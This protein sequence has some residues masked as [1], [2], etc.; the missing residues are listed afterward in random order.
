VTDKLILPPPMPEAL[1]EARLDR[2]AWDR[3][4]P[5]VAGGLDD[6]PAGR[7]HRMFA[8]TGGLAGEG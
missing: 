3:G 7:L 5:L 1:R 8:L 2:H 4:I 6:Q